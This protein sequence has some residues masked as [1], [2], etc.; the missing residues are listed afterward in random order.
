MIHRFPKIRFAVILMI[1]ALP[2]AAFAG[3]VGHP[4]GGGSSMQWQLNST[5]HDKA[6]LTWSCN[7]EVSSLDFK[8][9]KNVSLNASDLGDVQNAT[10]SWMVVLTPK[11]SKDV[12]AKLA[13][14]RAA[15]D[16]KAARKAIKDAGF[17]PDELIDS[18]SFSVSNGSFVNTSNV[19]GTS[20]ARP[21]GG[22]SS[23]AVSGRPNAP[24]TVNDQVIPDDL[25]VQGSACVGLDCVN[26]ESFGF[27]TIRLKENNTR[28]KFDDTSTSAGFPA[29]DWQL[30]A[31]DSASGGSS[32]F[33][34]ED[35][36]GSKVP[37]TVTAGAST[38]SIFVDSTGRVG[39]RTST[40]VLD[41]HIATS[42]TPA[43]RL[44][45]NNSG[46]F[47]AQ[48][49]DIGANEANFFV[50]DVTGG[51]KLS[52][53]IRPGAPTS[54]VDISA[55]GDVG[56]GTASPD[57]KLHIEKSADENVVAIIS[58]PNNSGLSADAAFQT[59]ADTAVLS[60][61]SHG[62]ARTISRFGHALGGWN[63]MLASAGNGLL[64][65]TIGSN[66]FTLGTN[67]TAR[68]TIAGTGAITIPGNLTVNG[69]FSNPS[70]RE[71]KKDFEVVDSKAILDKLMQVP[72]QEWTYKA[73]ERNLRH[74]GPM[75]EDFRATFG[76]GTDGQYMF[77]I[78]VQGVTMAAVQGLYE[79]LQEKDAQ[80]NDLQKQLAEIKQLLE[81]KQ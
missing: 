5:S 34:I 72:V 48:T 58:N 41:L 79:R 65:G 43:I 61:Q 42:N 59:K 28:I 20:A 56:I 27:D 75:V 55:D 14:A 69:T 64:I 68:M 74:V 25:I 22:L 15:N 10:C 52:F 17:N 32:K 3:P 76:L 60:F 36:T 78:D 57:N 39:F 4:V 51:S 40:P 71:L 73:D 29:N 7:G 62:T 1:V 35:I 63:E 44:E 67:S 11:V 81:R 21:A 12:A 13:A 70:S 24:I 8:N 80:I 45:Q 19:E 26:N 77:P 31:N 50:R 37:F 16:D 47:T 38:N 18:G 33:S 30:T 66:E 6:T 9:G 54:S 53:R 2:L 23:N 46:G 49:W